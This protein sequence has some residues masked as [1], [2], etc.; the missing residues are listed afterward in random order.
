MILG[1]NISQKHGGFRLSVEPTWSR[2]SL[3]GGIYSGVTVEKQ[4]ELDLLT[5]A[6]KEVRNPYMLH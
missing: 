4:M 2:S 1:S 5:E 3:H 6:L